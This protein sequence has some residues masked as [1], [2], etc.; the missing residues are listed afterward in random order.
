M[1]IIFA[2]VIIIICKTYDICTVP[3]VS[4]HI[5]YRKKTTF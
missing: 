5:F 2:I 1:I 3:F 4:P